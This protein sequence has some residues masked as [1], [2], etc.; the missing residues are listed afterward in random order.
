MMFSFIFANVIEATT[1][2]NAASSLETAI[3]AGTV[4][5][6][7]VDAA[8]TTL[9]FAS[10]S[11]VLTPT[12][13]EHNH[14][15]DEHDHDG[16]GF[17]DHNG[18]AVADHNHGDEKH[19]HD[20][21]GFNDHN[22]AAVNTDHNHVNEKH[23][24]DGDGFNDH[25]GAAV[26]AMRAAETNEKVSAAAVTLVGMMV[27]AAGVVGAVMHRRRTKA[28]VSAS[29]PYGWSNPDQEPERQLLSK[30]SP[31]ISPGVS[32]AGSRQYGA[33]N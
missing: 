16:D 26:G 10:I 27:L 2:V 23:D 1:A 4:G 32:R 14:H 21:D 17:N 11:S 22:G 6:I 20:G 19:D 18:A 29:S 12:F 25:N 9:S 28:R 24:H 3:N 7:A 33:A 30:G 15:N 5:S 13:V 31:G 8:G